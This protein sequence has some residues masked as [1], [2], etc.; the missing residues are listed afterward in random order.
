MTCVPPFLCLALVAVVLV[1]PPLGA[2]PRVVTPTGSPTARAPYPGARP[3]A[4]PNPFFNHWPCSNP[5]T[6]R[7]IC[8]STANIRP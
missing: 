2:E 6:P 8:R 3:G 4:P 7:G 5:A 1:A